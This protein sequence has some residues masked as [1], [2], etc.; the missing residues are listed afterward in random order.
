[1]GTEIV[2]LKIGA[3]H[4][5]AA[6]VSRNGAV[7]LTQVAQGPL[8]D[9]IV[10][11]GEVRDVPA[12]ALALKEFFKANKLPRKAVRIGIANNR[13]GVR[14]V[15]VVGIDDPKQ[16]ANAVRFRAQEVL[17]IPIGE[18]VLDYQ[19]LSEGVDEEGQPVTKVLMVVAYRDL[20]DAFASACRQAGIRLLGIDLEAF[21]LLRVLADG[22]L[23][24]APEGAEPSA[25]V[26]VSLG[27]ERS[28]LAISEGLACEYTR[29]LDW[30]GAALTG[31]LARAL[32]IDTPVAE[33]LKRQL[34]L[35]GEEVPADLTPE[36]AARAREALQLG[37]QGLARE[38]VSSLQFYQSQPGS[39]GIREVVLVGGS[40]KLDGLAPALERFIGVSVRIGD[41]FAA[42]SVRKQARMSAQDPALAVAIG[43]GMGM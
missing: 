23:V 18:A 37:L 43:L 29:V 9:G 35:E 28:T 2:G 10:Q 5:A 7:E 31:S 15:E 30:G 12:L 24:P 33:R 21:A 27:S 17:P 19:V 1:M 40:A 41:P 4:M 36:Q 6:R 26:A 42:V 38:L 22:A 14:T 39:L 16:L 20:V 3:S 8:G 25:L 11:S 13:T 32:D 34:S